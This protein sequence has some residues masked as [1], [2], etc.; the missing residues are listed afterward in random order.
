MAQPGL[1]IVRRYEKNVA[2]DFY[3]DGGCLFCGVPEAE[4]PDLLAPLEGDNWDTYFVRQPA[5]A[6]EVERACCALEVCCTDALRYAGTDAA[7]LHRLR[8]NPQI[9]DYRLSSNPDE[10]PTLAVQQV[11]ITQQ[12]VW[13]DGCPAAQARQP[14][15][16][17][18]PGLIALAASALKRLIP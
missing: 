8:A 7:I 17:S 14:P 13:P 12:E 2:G 18:R 1:P 4:A 16:D 10:P 11:E 15:T 9:C 5:T 3:T 6:A